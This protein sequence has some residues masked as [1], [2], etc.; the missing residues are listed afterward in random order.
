MPEASKT[1][2]SSRRS[3]SASAY[4]N[5][6]QPPPRTPTLRPMS[7]SAP[8]PSMNWVTFSAAMSV[9]VTIGPNDI[10]QAVDTLE[11]D[12]QRS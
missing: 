9:S 7:P 3:S 6:E 2:S 8:C 10:G 11:G 5:P 4:W 12:A 1:W